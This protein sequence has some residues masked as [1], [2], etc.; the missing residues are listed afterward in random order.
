MNSE[1]IRSKRR[2][3]SLQVKDD[4][5]LVI[6]VP[7]HIPDQY[8]IEIIERKKDWITKKQQAKSRQEHCQQIDFGEI[9]RGEALQKKSVR[10]N[11]YSAL[12]GLKYIRIKI[13]QAKQRWSSCSSKGSLNFAWRLVLAPQ[14]VIDYVVVQELAHL[15][16]RNHPKGFWREVDLFFPAYKQAKLWLKE[17]GGGIK[18]ASHYI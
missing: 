8:I 9:S 3:I 18:L 14:F 16:H 2:S 15:K 10:A 6:R 13:S 5:S 11:Y 7:Q 1:I 17:Y 12:S 4:A